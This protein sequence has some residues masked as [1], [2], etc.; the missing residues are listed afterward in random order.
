MR[1]TARLPHQFST[2]V[3]ISHRRCSAVVAR[4]GRRSCSPPLVTARDRR[5]RSPPLVLA[6]RL[7]FAGLKDSARLHRSGAGV[8]DGAGLH[9]G[10]ALAS[11]LTENREQGNPNVGLL[12]PKIASSENNAPS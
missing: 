8:G 1:R 4:H 11:F 6:A 3:F 12:Q 7:Q 5:S 9:R 10:G 2:R